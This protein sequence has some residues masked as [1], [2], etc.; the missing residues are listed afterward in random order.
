MH[1]RGQA[2]F[3]IKMNLDKDNLLCKSLPQKVSFFGTAIICVAVTFVHL[4][5][6]YILLNEY[7]IKV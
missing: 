1:G 7:P 5:K 3:T 6:P 2:F 4:T